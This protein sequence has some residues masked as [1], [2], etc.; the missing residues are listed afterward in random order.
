MSEVVL[1]PPCIKRTVCLGM[2]CRLLIKKKKELRGISGSLQQQC[3]QVRLTSLG[4][5]DK[6]MVKY[7][8]AT[9]PIVI[10]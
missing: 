4:T 2:E 9:T 8:L 5:T 3:T 10:Y 7:Q 6:I 1:F